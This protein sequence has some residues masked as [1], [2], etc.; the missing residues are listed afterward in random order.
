M[1]R[2]K[3]GRLENGERWDGKITRGHEETLGGVHVHDFDSNDGFLGVYVKQC[4]S[5]PIKYVQF[6]VYQNFLFFIIYQILSIKLL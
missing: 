2:P 3:A 5:I 4:Q 6:I 1:R